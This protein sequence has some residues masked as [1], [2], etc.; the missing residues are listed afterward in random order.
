MPSWRFIGRFSE[1]KNFH[2]D[3]NT[4]LHVCERFYVSMLITPSHV[5]DNIILIVEQ[6]CTPK[7]LLMAGELKVQFS[8]LSHIHNLSN[9]QFN[10]KKDI[11]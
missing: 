10:I 1:T 7:M 2:L 5:N 11:S 9:D 8:R 4:Y 6:S 3:T